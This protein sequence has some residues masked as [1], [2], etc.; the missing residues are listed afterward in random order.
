M[1]PRID[2]INPVVLKNDANEREVHRHSDPEELDESS[3][4]ESEDEYVA[5]ETKPKGK[6][7]LLFVW[8]M[9]SR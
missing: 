9:M 3:D 2:H 1:E 4:N 5:E 8:T 6:V 7:R